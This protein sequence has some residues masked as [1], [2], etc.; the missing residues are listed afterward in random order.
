[1]QIPMQI[2]FRGIESSEAVERRVREL[3]DRLERFHNHIT[4]CHVTI[5]APH[6]HQRQGVRYDIHLRIGVP[7]GEVDISRSGA[8]NGAHEDP[9]VAIRDAF[10][11]ATR[12]LED[13]VRRSD[14]RARERTAP[15]RGKVVRL[16][17]Q[18]GYGFIDTSDGLEVYFNEHAVLGPGFGKLEIGDE[19][20]LEV[21][22]QESDKGPQAST[23]H[24]RPQH[25]H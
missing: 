2:T 10:D 24:P 25:R 3:A 21:A 6:H 15:T 5:Q 7:N 1:M 16:F 13:V 12:Q 4:S 22:D 17:P 19:V 8:K 11:A 18:D 20:T 23:V 14:H 9:Y